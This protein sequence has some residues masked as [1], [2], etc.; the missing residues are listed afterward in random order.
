[1]INNDVMIG[2]NIVQLDNFEAVNDQFIYWGTY[3]LLPTSYTLYY[4]VYRVWSILYT[5]MTY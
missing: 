5:Y 3:V 4:N 1:M 2:I